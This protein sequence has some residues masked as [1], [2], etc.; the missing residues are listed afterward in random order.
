MVF[1]DGVSY[2]WT[3]LSPEL[4]PVFSFGLFLAGWKYWDLLQ[5]LVDC[6]LQKGNVLIFKLQCFLIFFQVFG[7]SLSL[8]FA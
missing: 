2:L 1:M 3:L 6:G 5:G 7:Q 8:Y 4:P